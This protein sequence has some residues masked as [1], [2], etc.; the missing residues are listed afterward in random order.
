MST[1]PKKHMFKRCFDE[2]KQGQGPRQ[3]EEEIQG[4]HLDSNVKYMTITVR[5]P[6]A[7]KIACGRVSTSMQLAGPMAWYRMV[8]VDLAP[9]P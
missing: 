7:F 1:T 2:C 3:R 4:T 9:G 6:G 8:V 5:R